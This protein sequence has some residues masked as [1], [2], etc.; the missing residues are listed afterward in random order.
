MIMT[1]FKTC[2]NGHNYDAG[3]YAVC[4]F[5]PV[6]NVNSDYEQTMKEFKRTQL[7]NDPN[8][9][10]FDKT[11]INEETK[12]LKTTLSGGGS[13]SATQN[14]LSRT[15][16][17]NRSDSK[18]ETV[19]D[20]TVKRKI[21]GWL[22]TFSI[23]DYGQDFKLFVG[24]NRI[25]SGKNCDILINDSS[26]SGEHATILFREDEFLI[27]DNFSTNGTK[28]NGVTTDEGKLKDGDELRL[29]NTV[30]KIKTV[31]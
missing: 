26:V 8:D 11:M 29:G 5:C 3:K 18:S 9:N 6:N 28:I 23:D 12:D 21:V 25:G 15:T 1:N 27:K 16:I 14:P 17:V 31:F 4:P 30:F 24:K 22:V 2:N 7:L 10:Q 19:I 13:G 20:Q